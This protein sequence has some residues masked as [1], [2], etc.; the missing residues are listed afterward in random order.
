MWGAEGRRASEGR[1]GG[2]SE[3]EGER[4]RDAWG[5]VLGAEEERAGQGG[6]RGRKWGRG[7][8]GETSEMN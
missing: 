7:E 2:G 6:E 8:G 5:R 1:E 3:V 4:G